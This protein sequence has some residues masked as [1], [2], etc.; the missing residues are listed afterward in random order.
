MVQGVDLLEAALMR[1]G[2]A[3][4]ALLLVF[5]PIGAVITIVATIIGVALVTAAIKAAQGISEL[6]RTAIK[7]GTSFENLSKIKTGFESMGIP[8]EAVTQGLK[9][10]QSE[11]D[12]F[13]MQRVNDALAEAKANMAAGWGAGA[14]NLKILQAAA[15]STNEA[16][17]RLARE[18]L[19]ALGQPLDDRVTPASKA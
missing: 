13:N 16:I 10:L 6:E 1:A 5:G 7:L 15:N 8:F 18:G 19:K 9:H 2:I 17:S 4:K 12:K 11:I 3:G 14:E